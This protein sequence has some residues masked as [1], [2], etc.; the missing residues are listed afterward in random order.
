[1]RARLLTIGVAA[2]LAGCASNRYGANYPPEPVKCANSAECAAMWSRVQLYLAQKSSYKIQLVTDSIIQTYSGA[3]YE[4]RLSYTITRELLPD[5]A[6]LI[7]FSAGCGNMFGCV[8]SAGEA[9]RDFNMYIS[10]AR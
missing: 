1:M 8:P 10:A 5:G 2:V 6:G 7:R 4:A 3:H 9:G